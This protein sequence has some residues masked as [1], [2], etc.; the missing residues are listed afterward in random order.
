MINSRQKGKR[1]ER[2]FATELKAVFP[3]IRRNAGTQSQSGGVDL[4]NTEPFN[5]E[6]KCGKDCQIAK[7]R[8]WLD[9]V[10]VEGKAFFYD[11][12]LV[13]P[14]REEPFVVMPFNDFEALLEILSAEGVLKSRKD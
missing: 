8:K 6:V 11:A 5:F 12:V 9:Q 2:Y 4:E 1:G 13:K 14:D 10:K 3:K 7:V